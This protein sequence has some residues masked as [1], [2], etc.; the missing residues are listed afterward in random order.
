MTTLGKN[1]RVSPEQLAKIHR[2]DD[3]DLMMLI[4]EIHDHGWPLASCTLDIMPIGGV[5]P[6]PKVIKAASVRASAIIRKMQ[7]SNELRPN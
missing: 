6:N 5:S 2:L 3:F 1:Q 4:S 7:R